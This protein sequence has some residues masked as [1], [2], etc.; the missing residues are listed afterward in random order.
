[1]ALYE[2]SNDQQKQLLT[3]IANAQ[4]RGGDAPAIIKLS[5]TLQTPVK[6]KVKSEKVAPKKEDI[7]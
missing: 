5:Q 4:I 7:K 3:I 2:I 1:M 6:E